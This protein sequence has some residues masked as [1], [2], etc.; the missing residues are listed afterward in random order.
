MTESSRFSATLRDVVDIT[1][2]FEAPDRRYVDD[3]EKLHR[4]YG[5]EIEQVYLIGEFAVR[6][7]RIG[8]DYFETERHRYRPK[9]VMA[10]ESGVS[11]GDLLADGYPFFNGTI[12]LVS[13]VVVPAT[14]KGRRYFLKLG[15]LGA[16]VASIQVNQRDAGKIAW[17]PYSVDVTHLVWQGENR[18]EIRLTNS[19]RNLLG[20]LHFVPLKDRKGQWSLKAEPRLANGPRWYENREKNKTWSDDYFL[21]PLGTAGAR[22]VCEEWS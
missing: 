10:A 2:Q 13:H 17:Q 6:G 21:R 5:T 4:Y 14:E 15:R 18:I 1:R 12:S 8:S 3:D 9:F 22:I 19:L 7:E 20:G 16:T 11:S